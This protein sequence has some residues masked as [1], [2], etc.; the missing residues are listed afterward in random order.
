MLWGKS[1]CTSYNSFDPHI[2]LPPSLSTLTIRPVF[3]ILQTIHTSQT[4]PYYIHSL[5]NFHVKYSKCAGSL[6]EIHPREFW[7]RTSSLEPSALRRQLTQLQRNFAL[8]ILNSRALIQ[9]KASL[10]RKDYSVD[11]RT[12]K[13]NSILHLQFRRLISLLFASLFRWSPVAS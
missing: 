7:K 12:L 10:R 1:I 5:P 11:L 4:A 8:V 9:S 3:S 13:V 6:V 2:G